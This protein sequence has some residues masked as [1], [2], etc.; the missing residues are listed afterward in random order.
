MAR[1]LCSRQ[2]PSTYTSNARCR[3]TMGF[4]SMIA[5]VIV[6]IMYVVLGIQLSK[7]LHRLFAVALQSTF[8]ADSKPTDAELFF[9]VFGW[10]FML[11]CILLAF[12]SN[13]VVWVFGRFFGFVRW[14][15]G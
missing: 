12:C 5:I 10:P 2:A 14:W 4:P 8:Y 15:N 13:G 11:L 9:L 3:L 1:P 6:S 7:P